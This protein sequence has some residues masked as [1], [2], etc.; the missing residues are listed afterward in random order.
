MWDA[1]HDA[2]ILIHQQN[3]LPSSFF[4][5]RAYA[6]FSVRES[7]VQ[8]KTQDNYWKGFYFFIKAA[9]A[10]CCFNTEHFQSIQGFLHKLLQHKNIMQNIPDN[11]GSYYIMDNR[12]LKSKHDSTVLWRC[13]ERGETCGCWSNTR[14]KSLIYPK[15]SMASRTVTQRKVAAN[16]EWALI[17]RNKW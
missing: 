4:I 13:L 8:K 14:T 15:T 5:I 16:Q 11:G 9:E 7:W 2:K 17:S 6:V 10:A 1:N 12:A 3:P